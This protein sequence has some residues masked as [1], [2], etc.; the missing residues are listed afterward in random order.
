MFFYTTKLDSLDSMKVLGT[1]VVICL[2]LSFA[3]VNFSRHL[4][5]AYINVFN[6][7]FQ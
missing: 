2:R 6:T 4:T 7:T 5:I 1:Q 3:V